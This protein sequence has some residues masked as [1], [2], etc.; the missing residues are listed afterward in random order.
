MLGLNTILSRARAG[1]ND[2][3]SQRVGVGTSSPPPKAGEPSSQA[4]NVD[5]EPARTSEHVKDSS[6]PGGLKNNSAGHE[7]HAAES[8]LAS[9]DGPD[10]VIEYGNTEVPGPGRSRDSHTSQPQDSSSLPQP[11][12]A[13]DSTFIPAQVSDLN[14]DAPDTAEVGHV[15]AGDT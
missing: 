7:T 5:I 1:D 3:D 11:S 8:P 14:H 12:E 6:H 13:L 2:E 4:F 10:R 9:H 15:P